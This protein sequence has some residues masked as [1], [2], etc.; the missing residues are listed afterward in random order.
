MASKTVLPLKVVKEVVEQQNQNLIETL[1]E[2]ADKEYLTQIK[3]AREDYKAG[4]V[5]SIDQLK[6]ILSRRRKK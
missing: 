4:R 3:E 1:E 5:V 2:L 6:S